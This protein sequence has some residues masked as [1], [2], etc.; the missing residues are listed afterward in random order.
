M[1]QG[2][3]YDYVDIERYAFEYDYTIDKFDF[4]VL[5]HKGRANILMF[6]LQQDAKNWKLDFHGG[7]Q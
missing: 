1:K 4:I 7:R 5:L 2:R 6:V 3:M